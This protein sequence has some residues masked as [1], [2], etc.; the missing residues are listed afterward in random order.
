MCARALNE[1]FDDGDRESYWPD[2]RQTGSDVTMTSSGEFPRRR[3]RGIPPAWRYSLPSTLTN[4][5]SAVRRPA[6]STLPT[7][8]FT[9]GTDNEPVSGVA[10]R[11][12]LSRYI[13][14]TGSRNVTAA[15]SGPKIRPTCLRYSYWLTLDDH[16]RYANTYS[17]SPPTTS[18]DKFSGYEDQL[19]RHFRPRSRVVIDDDSRD[20]TASVRVDL[21]GNTDELVTNRADDQDAVLRRHLACGHVTDSSAASGQAISSSTSALDHASRTCN[22]STVRLKSDVDDRL[23]G[24]VNSCSDV[25]GSRDREV[26][27]QGERRLSLGKIGDS[28]L[29]TSI[30]SEQNSPEETSAALE[31]NHHH[32]HQQ[33]QQQQLRHQRLS[34]D[35][36]DDETRASVNEFQGRTQREGHRERCVQGQVDE[37]NDD[38]EDDRT[39]LTRHKR[40]LYS[41]HSCFCLHF[42]VC[43]VC[44]CLCVC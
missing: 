21:P 31:D 12:P 18:D 22:S 3:R 5:I 23:P 30:H 43:V 37:E 39:K 8:V 16:R 41:L 17:T 29:G 33:Q 35:D 10:R 9:S 32:H 24:R 19:T 44:V 4:S 6:D 28:G 36:D 26:K 20:P 11:R 7:P 25:S 27:G 15:E 14:M 40:E 38:D 42:C 13:A 34:D 2:V 1:S